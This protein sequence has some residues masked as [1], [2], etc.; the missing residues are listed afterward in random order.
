M[1]DLSPIFAASLLDTLIVPGST[2]WLSLHTADPGTTGA[3]EFVGGAYVRQPITFG[4]TSI[5]SGL[6]QNTLQA[7]FVELP[8]GNLTN[9]GIWDS[10]TNGDY[11]IG[12]SAL[13][14]NDPAI[15]SGATVSFNLANVLIQLN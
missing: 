8:P 1:T 15:P 11:I 10:S 5:L 7:V 4:A 3:F 12:A 6:K 13:F 14:T 2:Y 9:S